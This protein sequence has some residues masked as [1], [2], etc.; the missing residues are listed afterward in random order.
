MAATWLILALLAPFL[1]AV[2]NIIDK[3][4]LERKINNYYSY[5][6]ILGFFYILF[7][8]LVWLFAGFP[9]LTPKLLLVALVAGAC[10]GAVH[11]FYSYYMTH[12]EVSRAAGI[13]FIFPAFVAILSRIILGEQIPTLKYFAIALAIIGGITLG[14]ESFSRFRFMRSFWF[15]I[16]NVILLSVTSVADKYLLSHINYFHTYILE[17]LVVALMIISPLFSKKVRAD[18]KQAMHYR[19]IIFIISLIGLLGSFAFLAATSMAPVTLVT[20]MA[21]TQPAYVFIISTLLSIFMP[22]IIKERIS[23]RIIVYKILGIALVVTAAI[24]LGS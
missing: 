14:M 4:L 2:I 1:F 12:V 7:A 6:V 24:I 19:S 18:M 16:L 13:V 22:H 10:Y 15:I 20:A 9:Q 3:H 23:K 11:F 21:T 8:F 17:T 5:L